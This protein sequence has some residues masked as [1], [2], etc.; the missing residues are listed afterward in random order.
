MGAREL[1]LDILVVKDSHRWFFWWAVPFLTFL[2]LTILPDL[3]GIVKHSKPA[4]HVSVFVRKAGR[5][6]ERG[7]LNSSRENIKKSYQPKLIGPVLA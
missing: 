7:S 3:S 4:R 5:E 6:L 2:V 1:S